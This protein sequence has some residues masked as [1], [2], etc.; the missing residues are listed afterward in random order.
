M[1]K[2]SW[3]D[4]VRNI[5]KVNWISHMSLRNC[6]MIHVIEGEVEGRIDVKVRRERRRKQLPDKL[7]KREDT[8]G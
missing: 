8:G 4:H 7:K 3:S 5:S 6:F 1:E 2:I